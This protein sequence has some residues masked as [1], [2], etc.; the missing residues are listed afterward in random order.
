MYDTVLVSL[1]TDTLH[2]TLKLKDLLGVDYGGLLYSEFT[3]NFHTR[4]VSLQQ[5]V[6]SHGSEFERVKLK[7][8]QLYLLLAGCLLSRL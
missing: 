7:S 5:R 1:N 4:L 8:V 6:N 2:E 3:S